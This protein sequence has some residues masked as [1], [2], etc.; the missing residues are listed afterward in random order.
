MAVF[1]LCWQH[2]KCAY[3]SPA[4]QCFKSQKT[5]QINQNSQVKCGVAHWC[6][7]LPRGQSFLEKIKLLSGWVGRRAQFAGSEK[8][9]MQYRKGCL[10]WVVSVQGALSIINW[11]RQGERGWGDLKTGG[12]STE[13]RSGDSAGQWDVPT[14]AKECFIGGMQ[15]TVDTM[16]K[17]RK[18]YKPL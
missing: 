4:K 2:L 18:T 16:K 14:T 10:V 6:H 5:K 11:G 15:W 17:I 3:F 12:D 8:K 13:S 7:V 9:C 1:L